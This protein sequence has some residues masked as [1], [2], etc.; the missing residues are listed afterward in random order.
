[1]SYWPP[2]PKMLFCTLITGEP[3]LVATRW[4]LLLDARVPFNALPLVIALRSQP[5]P[6]MPPMS[7]S[8]IELTQ[9][10]KLTFVSALGTWMMTCEIGV[11]PS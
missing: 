9:K 8:A 7:V 2:L 11:V 5:A 6:A 1:M 10:S 4:N 3:V